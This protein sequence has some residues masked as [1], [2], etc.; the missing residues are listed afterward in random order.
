MTQA[1]TTLIATCRPMAK[2]NRLAE[3]IV[4]VFSSF[5]EADQ[6]DDEFYKGLTSQQSLDIMVGFVGRE[7]HAAGG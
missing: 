1:M 4:R 5:E 3:K 6:A 2:V 7:Q